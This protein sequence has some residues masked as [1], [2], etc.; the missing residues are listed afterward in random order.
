MPKRILIIAGEISGDMHASRLVQ[1]LSQGDAGF[2]FFGIGGPLMRDAGVETLYDIKDMA[3]TGFVEVL[4][5]YFFFRRVFNHMLQVARERKPDA[6]ILVDYPGF[7]LR[8]AAKAHKMG[9]KVVY[10]ICPQVWAWHRSRI[11]HMAEIVDHLVTIFPFE[12]KHFDGTGLKVDFAGHPL[13]DEARK[14]LAEP[15]KDLPWKGDPRVAL[16]PGSRTNEIEH[17]LP[18]MW[19]AAAELQKKHADAAFLIAAPSEKIAGF[20]HDTV[21]KLGPGPS[22]WEIVTG[23]ARQVLRQARAAMVTSG[24]ATIETSLMECPMAVVY[25]M[26]ALNYLLARTLV[27]I[28]HIGMVNIVAGKE[29]CPE[30][31]QDAAT[32]E[33]LAEAISAL[34][35][36]TPER[37]A[38]LQALRES[39]IALG[40]GGAAERAAEIIRPSLSIS[41]AS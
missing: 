10:Y 29:V 35:G 15:L 1:T 24:T 30:F 36:D 14:A 4:K 27:K 9:I 33:A 25:K 37:A 3:V 26:P 20:V 28:D 31:I 19:H 18:V 13:V 39:N 41:G 8:F 34:L 40:E 2:S 11:P 23:E 17:I 22:R 5:R 12:G 21:E 7:N 6:V 16:L 38:M 32:P